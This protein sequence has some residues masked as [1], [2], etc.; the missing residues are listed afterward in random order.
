MRSGLI[1]IFTALAIVPGVA[2]AGENLGST[3][4][5]SVTIRVAVPPLTAALQGQAEG[6]VGLNS[7]VDTKSAI[8]ISL[9]STVS[10]MEIATAAVY[11]G[12]DNPVTLFMGQTGHVSLTPSQTQRMNG[13]IRQSFTFSIRASSTLLAEQSRGM[14]F[15]VT[16][17]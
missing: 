3:S 9:P 11:A 17:V 13:M 15:V 1:S 12:S 8:M 7:V 6:A 10:S 16:P 5:G 4:S 2:S 14:T